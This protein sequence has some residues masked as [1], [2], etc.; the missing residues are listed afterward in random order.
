MYEFWKVKLNRFPYSTLSFVFVAAI[1]LY[2][3]ISIETINRNLVT[4]Y[5]SALQV[6][7]K[8]PDEYFLQVAEFAFQFTDTTRLLQEV[9]YFQ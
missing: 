7:L 2:R 6:E 1:T 9:F 5:H 3:N 8:T 4:I